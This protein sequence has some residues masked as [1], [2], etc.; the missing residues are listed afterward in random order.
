MI[1]GVHLS[2]AGCTVAKANRAGLPEVVERVAMGAPEPTLAALEEVLA[3]HQV[4]ADTIVG[5]AC[6]NPLDWRRGIIQSPPNMPGWDQ[7]PVVAR[8][9][10]RLGCRVFLMN[11]ANA[12][13]LA[14]W[15]F[16]SGREC[17]NM[18]YLTA[19]SGMGAGL[20]LDGKLYE[21]TTGSAGEVAT[22]AWHPMDRKAT[23]K[24]DRW[25]VSVAV[26]A[27]FS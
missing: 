5:I 3:R 11:N 16:G 2:A 25:K 23:A 21:G 6:G 20:I 22:S 4:G 1:L 17:R 27:S 14:E 26:A 8:W 19:G 24:R 9:T 18:I 7:V 15:R 13:A 10:A 12:S